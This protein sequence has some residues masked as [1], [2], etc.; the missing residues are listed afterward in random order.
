[1]SK[2]LQPLAGLPDTV[3]AGQEKAVELAGGNGPRD[4]LNLEQWKREYV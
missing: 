1:M 3:R 2:G 4:G